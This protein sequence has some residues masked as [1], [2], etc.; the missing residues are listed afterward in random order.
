MVN[1]ST[2]TFEQYCDRVTEFHGHLAPGML[3]GGFMVDLALR[4]LPKDILFDVICETPAC[5][6][7][8]I[9]LLTP[10]SVGNQW[11]KVVDVGRYAATFYNKYTGEGVRVYIDIDRLERWPAIR[12]WYLKLKP[13]KQ[14][15]RQQIFDQIKEAGGQICGIETI[16]VNSEFLARPD[17]TVA[18]CPVCHESYR[19]EDGE[20]CPAC[21]EDCL[22]YRVVAKTKSA[23]S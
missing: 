7:D 3:V 14:Q 16:K 22:P 11:L 10:C 4:N 21:K 15:D 12:E 8:A 19:S 20:I 18:V 6:P 2:Y 1:I 13:K 5:L 23:G 17:K 9:Q